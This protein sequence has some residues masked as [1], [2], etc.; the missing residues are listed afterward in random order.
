MERRSFIKQSCQACAAIALG[1]AL[2]AALESCASTAVLKTTA[3]NNIVSVPLTAFAEK[4]QVTLRVSGRAFDLLCVKVEENTFRTLEMKCTH[5]DQPLVS[6][7]KSLY[8]NSHGSQFD[9]EG[10][11]L[12]DPASRPLRKFVTAIEGEQVLIQLS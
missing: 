2:V 7:G 1:P 12:K 3:Q 6:S 11:V 5:Q 9:L 10:K 4:N 8:C